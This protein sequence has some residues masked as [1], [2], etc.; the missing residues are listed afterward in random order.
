MAKKK[1]G[2]VN[3]NTQNMRANISLARFDEQIQSAQY[4]LDSQVMT[5]MVPY[6]PHETGT[7]INVTRA[8]SAS[9]AG[10]GMVCAGTGPM[11]RFLYYGKGMVDELTGSPWARKGAKKVLVTEFAGHTNAKE[12]CPIPIQKQLQNGLKQQ[13]RITAKHGLLMLRSRQEEVDGRR[14]EISQV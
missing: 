13:R 6:M 10:T 1:L 9:L 5:D 2:N 8:K 3:V 11:G 14:K 12:T 4:W 7:F